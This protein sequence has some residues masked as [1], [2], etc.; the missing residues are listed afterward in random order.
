MIQFL[1]IPP[2]FESVKHMASQIITKTHL[3]LYYYCYLLQVLLFCRQ[4]LGL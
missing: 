1:H 4:D 2:D 3:D